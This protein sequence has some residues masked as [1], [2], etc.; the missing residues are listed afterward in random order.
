MSICETLLGRRCLSTADGGGRGWRDTMR[1]KRKP[2]SVQMFF[3]SRVVVRHNDRRA[4]VELYSSLVA[5][6]VELSGTPC[7][8]SDAVGSILA[9][10]S[11][12][13]GIERDSVRPRSSRMDAVPGDGD[14]HGAVHR[15]AVRTGNHGKACRRRSSRLPAGDLLA[16]ALCLQVFVYGFC[17]EERNMGF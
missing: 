6:V 4:T 9:A 16:N 8:L 10:V 7:R 1:P 14:L 3:F 5:N 17:E 13:P 15:G 12:L 2:P 11:P